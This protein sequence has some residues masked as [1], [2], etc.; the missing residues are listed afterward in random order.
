[1]NPDTKKYIIAAIETHK[2]MIVD[3]EK[4]GIVTIVGIAEVITNALKQNGTVY[5]CGNGGSAAC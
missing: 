3:F 4:D 1:M 2:K 5:L